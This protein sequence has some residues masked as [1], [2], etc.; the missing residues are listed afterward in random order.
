M[1]KEQ[2]KD[3]VLNSLKDMKQAAPNAFLFTRIESRLQKPIVITPWQLSLATIALA[4][5]L[6]A[7]ALLVLRT[8][9]K[10]GE[11]VNQ[12]YRISGFQSY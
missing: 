5:L 3:E 11:P 12:E 9:N 4:L 1:E 2:W 6:A 10:S 7:N 8:I